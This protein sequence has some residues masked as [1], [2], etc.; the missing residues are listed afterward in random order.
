MLGMSATTGA[1]ID[2]DAHLAQSIG[3]ILSTPIGTRVMRRDYGS[4]LFELLDAPLTPATRLLIFAST[5]IA[6]RRWEPRLLLTRVG[7]S[8]ANGSGAA[9]LSIEGTRTDAPAGNSLVALTVPLRARA[10]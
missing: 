9:T 5:A 4:A 7:F 1:P 6:L 10:A 3:D 8:A 2:G